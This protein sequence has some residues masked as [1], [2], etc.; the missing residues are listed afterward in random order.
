MIRKIQ[1]QAIVFNTTNSRA[2][3]QN[4]IRP[5]GNTILFTGVVIVGSWIVFVGGLK[6]DWG[7]SEGFK[8]SSTLLQI[9][10]L[11]ARAN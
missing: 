4:S 5:G 7:F 1:G 2:T 3:V 11:K 6:G 9:S 8:Q 10:E